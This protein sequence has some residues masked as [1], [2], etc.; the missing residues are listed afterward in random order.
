MRGNPPGT[1]FPL[2]PPDPAFRLNGVYVDVFRNASDPDD[3]N[4]WQGGL[5]SGLP[6]VASSGKQYVVSAPLVVPP[7]GGKVWGLPGS[8]IMC[9]T[10][11]FGTQ[12]LFTQASLDVP[13]ADLSVWSLTV[14]RP[15]QGVAGRFFSLH[16]DNL[17]L[18]GVVCDTFGSGGA[19]F[20]AGANI[21]LLNCVAQNG[22]TAV[23]SAGIRMFGGSGVASGC[24]IASGD[25]AFQL[26]PLAQGPGSNLSITSFVYS[27]CIGVSYSAEL[28]AVELTIQG[29]LPGLTDSIL[30]WSF[31]DVVGSS[32][33][34]AILVNNVSSSGAINGGALT[35]ISVDTTVNNGAPQVSF[36]NGAGMG[37]VE[38]ITTN[39][40]VIHN[41]PT[42]TII[43]SGTS[44]VDTSGISFS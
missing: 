20:V 15:S 29:S 18:S 6:L 36:H 24:N 28:I 37:G 16:C 32:G 12:G 10:A 39:G 31:V 4:A 41:A 42:H 11:M 19:F 30:N 9:P 38:N 17:L 34:R 7:G 14:K 8:S 44:N 43:N 33:F 2:T 35:N 40:V 5:N 1:S 22:Q 13:I 27:N 23:G 21:A 3:T 25:Q 26:S